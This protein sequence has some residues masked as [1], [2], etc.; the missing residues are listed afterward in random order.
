MKVY[1]TRPLPEPSVSELLAGFEVEIGVRGEGL[2]RVAPHVDAL[3]PTPADAVT[4]ALLESA[5][6]LR[7]VANCAVG[8]DNIDKDACRE[9]GIVVTNTPGVLTEATADLTWALILALTRRL[10]EGEA[11]VRS[12]TWDGWKPMELLGF[13]L[14]G[15]TLG[16]YGAGRI[17]QAVARRAAAFGM[18][19]VTF[20]SRD[21]TERFDELLET[22]D[23]LSVHAP[24]TPATR[25]RF[26]RA[27][28]SRMKRGALFVN[29]ARGGLMDEAAL[30][31]ALEHGPLGGAA[32]DVY[33][34]EPRVDARLL[35]RSDVVLLPHIG[36]ATR[37]TRLQMARLACEE[38]RRVLSGEA[39]VNRVV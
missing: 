38:I 27:E 22:S 39:P 12:G 2:S 37:E 23:I 31:D 18:G 7:I 4:R 33:E 26:G 25:L 10:R 19:V 34:H 9:R 15:K 29:T 28:L 17:G 6:R 24:L 32:L 1:V 14:Q 35:S 8:T 21:A 30:V 11:L 16:I 36:S 3:L 5:P 20:T 13:G